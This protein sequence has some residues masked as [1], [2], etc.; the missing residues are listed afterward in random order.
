[1]E[2]E[3]GVNDLEVRR[4]GE[5]EKTLMVAFNEGALLITGDGGTIGVAISRGTF[6]SINSES[7]LN[8]RFEP[9]RR[10]DFITGVVALSIGTIH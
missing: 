4:T 2:G 7:V 8:P 9:T 5:A 10:V 6:P 3:A 1:M